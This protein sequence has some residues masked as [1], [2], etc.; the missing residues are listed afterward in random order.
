MSDD[1]TEITRIA[2]PVLFPNENL[3]MFIIPL[4]LKILSQV[5]CILSGR[6]S[7]A[8]FFIANLLLAGL[9]GFELIHADSC[10]NQSSE[11]CSFV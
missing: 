8:T 11:S 3:L 9:S 2:E 7:Y 6:F 1:A 5:I 4:L 10:R